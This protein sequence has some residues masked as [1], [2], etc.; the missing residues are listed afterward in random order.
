MLSESAVLDRIKCRDDFWSAKAPLL[1][2]AAL[3]ERFNRVGE[4][5]RLAGWLRD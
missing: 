5:W 1:G 4:F 2:H 3:A